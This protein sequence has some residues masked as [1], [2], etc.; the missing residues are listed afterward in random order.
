MSSVCKLCLAAGN[1]AI[2]YEYAD[3]YYAHI[4]S[5]HSDVDPGVAWR[6]T[7]EP[8]KKAR[9]KKAAPDPDDFFSKPARKKR[10]KK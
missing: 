6:S 10:A 7:H 3:D 4:L 1:D 2:E 8:V 5:D 9:K